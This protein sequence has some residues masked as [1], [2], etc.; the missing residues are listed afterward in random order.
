MSEAA[1]GIEEELKTIKAEI[2]DIRDSIMTEDD[3]KA[4]LDYRKEKKA[5]KLVPHHKVWKELGL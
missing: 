5:G 1:N 2:S 4:L 3:Y